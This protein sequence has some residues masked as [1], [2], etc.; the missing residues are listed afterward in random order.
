MEAEIKRTMK[1][2]KIQRDVVSKRDSGIGINGGSRGP[3]PMANY[4][5]VTVG[6]VGA[7]RGII[8]DTEN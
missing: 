1:A 7:P 6:K 8:F 4:S 3:P 2:S 5:H